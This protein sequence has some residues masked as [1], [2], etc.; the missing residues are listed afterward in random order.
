MKLKIR[1]LLKDKFVR[2]TFILTVGNFI[3]SVL[4]YLIHPILTRHLSISAYG[5]FQAILSFLTIIGI[6]GVVI[7]T[8]LTKEVS[9]LA[10][11]KLDQIKP[12]W[13][14]A[15]F[16]LS[17]LG[18][19]L[20]ILVFIFS[21]LLNNLF[22]IP[23]SSVLLI[24][25]LSLLYIFPM[26]VNRAVLTGLQR[27]PVLAGLNLIDPACR[28]ILIILLVVVWPWGIIGAAWSLGLTSLIGFIV[29]FWPIKKLKLPLVK[30]EEKIS[31]K[32]LIPYAGL[33]LWLT[34][35]SQFF[36]NF[37]MLLVK[38]AFSP[39]EAGLYGALLTIGRIIFF[40]GGSV[41]L[42]M[43]P[44]I[45]G[46]KNDVSLHKYKV[47]LKSL[48]LMA[49][50]AIPTALVIALFPEFV[51]KI[52]VGL[53]YLSIVQYLPAFALV[54][55]L[56][57]MLTVLAQ[58]FLALSRRSGLWALTVGAITEIISLSLFHSSFWVVI[59]SLIL[60]FIGINSILFIL[61]FLDYKKDK[62]RLYVTKD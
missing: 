26:F 58:Y 5:D 11:N 44:V 62:Q 22:K 25:S 18:I 30:S 42:V 15:M 45:A 16:F 40:V 51:V 4:N 38:S 59:M 21:G 57:T 31:L 34:A 19:V 10:A 17:W 35:L 52:V 23:E 48:G 50:L 61:L 8:A 32:K 46:L 12:L 6:I 1:K 54:I 47:L 37:D 36:Y 55:F 29:S 53:K 27:F 28:L 2:G 14:R 7:L 49:L 41:P 43:F 39:E 20:F 33:V 56:L 24:S 60:V 9:V 3:G 13:R